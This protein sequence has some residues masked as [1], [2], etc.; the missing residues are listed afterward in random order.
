MNQNK[1]SRKESEI[2]NLRNR[3]R[4]YEKRLIIISAQE[5]I[6][7]GIE[8][9]VLTDNP[10]AQF[11]EVLADPKVIQVYEKGEY[12]NPYELIELAKNVAPSLYRRYHES[13]RKLKER[14]AELK[15]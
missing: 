9:I 14:I 11:N 15:N 10:D 12:S 8:K 4:R 7:Q 1:L 6:K 3:V 2:L 13:L 5:A